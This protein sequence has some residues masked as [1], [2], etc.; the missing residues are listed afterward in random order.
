MTLGSET[1]AMQLES[2]GLHTRMLPSTLPVTA[3][4]PSEVNLPHVTPS[5]CP[6]SDARVSTSRKSARQ[7]SLQLAAGYSCNLSAACIAVRCVALH[8]VNA[9]CRVKAFAS[10]CPTL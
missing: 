3:H 10:S 2:L 6:A 1:A 8:C 4:L 9:L 7:T 5:L